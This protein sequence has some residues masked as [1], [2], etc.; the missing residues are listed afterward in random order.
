VKRGYTYIVGSITGVLYIGVTSALG[1]RIF[2]H[3]NGIFEG[4]SKTY[5]CTRLLYFEFCILNAMKT[6]AQPSLARNNSKAGVAR[7][8]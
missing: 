8:N 1:L 5:N 4:F 3:K 7:R 6:F 2:Q